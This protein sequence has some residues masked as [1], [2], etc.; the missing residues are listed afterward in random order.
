MMKKIEQK[1]L[2]ST[3][4][5]GIAIGVGVGMFFF[6]LLVPGAPQLIKM[7]NVNRIEQ[8]MAMHRSMSSQGGNTSV[9]YMPIAS[10][11]NMF[12]NNENQFLVA[13]ISHHEDAVRMSHQVLSIKGISDN[14]KTLAEGI[15]DSQSAEISI[16]QGWLKAKK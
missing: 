5:L 11:S 16:M 2:T 10:N 8:R 7:Y 12:I 4:F 6:S 1:H 13:M 14:V 9:M 3:L 15:I